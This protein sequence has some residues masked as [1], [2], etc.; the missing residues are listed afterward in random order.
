L[1]ALRS[2]T[3]PGATLSARV[4]SAVKATLMSASSSG[5]S[6]ARG[7]APPGAPTI[8]QSRASLTS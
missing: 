6:P 8:W 3:A 4:T 7:A 1:S 2:I 5:A